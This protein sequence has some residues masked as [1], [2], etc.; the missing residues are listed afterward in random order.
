MQKVPDICDGFLPSFRLTQHSAPDVCKGQGLW[1]TMVLLVFCE[2]SASQAGCGGCSGLCLSLLQTGWV[3]GPPKAVGS[4]LHIESRGT[5]GHFLLGLES[6]AEALVPEPHTCGFQEPR[7]E[8]GLR[9]ACKS[10]GRD[11]RT[12][13]GVEGP[14]PQQVAS[15]VIHV[16]SRVIHVKRVPPPEFY[17]GRATAPSLGTK[18]SPCE[19]SLRLVLNSPKPMWP[20][21][22]FPS[23]VLFPSFSLPRKELSMISNISLTV[24]DCG[25]P[26]MKLP[27]HPLAQACGQGNWPAP[28]VQT[29]GRFW[30]PR[31]VDTS[32]S[33]SWK[34]CPHRMPPPTLSST[35]CFTQDC[36]ASVHLAS[37][38][39][40]LAQ[41][42]QL[43]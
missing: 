14:Q 2:D 1:V 5:M 26:C 41:G 17:C 10:Q 39:S 6:G 35:P 30:L 12:T 22:S 20:Q 15:R 43:C 29:G 21:L 31:P 9:Q 32:W 8:S 28:P 33:W 25:S 27:T 38:S 3:L 42:S 4:D 13:R 40:G 16:S 18:L 36:N 11:L 19:S 7:G 24:E 23:K 34:G 37:G